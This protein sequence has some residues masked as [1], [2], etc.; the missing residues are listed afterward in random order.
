[1]DA[2][3]PMAPS[4]YTG[5]PGTCVYGRVVVKRGPYKIDRRDTGNTQA[6]SA[7]GKRGGKK[8][9][10]QGSAASNQ[11]QKTEIHLVGGAGME[12]V[13]FMEAWGD[14]AREL[15]NAVSRGEVYRI[16]GAKG[17]TRSRNTPLRSCRIISAPWLR[18]V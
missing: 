3:M 13:L 18:W 17:L 12:E 7:K 14:A 6:S 11:D 5:E 15:A 10:K 9:S 4:E 16:A 8:G 2:L 1:M